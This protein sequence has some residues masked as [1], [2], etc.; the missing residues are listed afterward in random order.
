MSYDVKVGPQAKKELARLERTLARRIRDRLRELAANPYD[1]RLSRQ[2]EMDP[3]KR[4]SRVGNWRII[5]AVNEAEQVLE[6]AA[7]QHRS[8]VYKKI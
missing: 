2:L 6:A 8:K 4:Y 7:V 1:P 3:E 5:F